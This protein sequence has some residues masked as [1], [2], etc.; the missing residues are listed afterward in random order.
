M[1][2]NMEIKV[3]Y[4]DSNPLSVDTLDDLKRVEKE[5]S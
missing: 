4:S 1:E 2:N 3:G 5:M